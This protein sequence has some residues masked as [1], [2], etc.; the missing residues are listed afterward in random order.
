[1]FDLSSCICSEFFRCP[2]PDYANVAESGEC[3]IALSWRASA[4]I[5]LTSLAYIR[6]HVSKT[7]IPK[8][9]KA[10]LSSR[11][12]WSKL[13]WRATWC[14]CSEG[15]RGSHYVHEHVLSTAIPEKKKADGYRHTKNISVD[16]P[17]RHA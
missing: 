8:E 12:Y 9:K 1:M 6:E 17:L 10:L 16:V 3:P 5:V 2:H 4:R 13:S 15:Q 11:L 7:G 14:T